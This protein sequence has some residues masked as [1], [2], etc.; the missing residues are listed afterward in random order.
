MATPT[1]G[2]RIRQLEL[3]LQELSTTVGFMQ[4]QASGFVQLQEDFRLDLASLD[5][6]NAVLKQ[7][8]AEQTR[9]LDEQV[10]HVKVWDQRWWGL[11]AGVLFAIVTAF[12][13]K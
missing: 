4:T 12:I 11:V 7:T 13:R 6:E 5:K 2:E 10:A 8:I 3:T 1:Q 9:R